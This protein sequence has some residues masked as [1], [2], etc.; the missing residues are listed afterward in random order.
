[1]SKSAPC[2]IFSQDFSSFFSIFSGFTS[3]TLRPG[4]PLT[5]NIP[6]EGD[7]DVHDPLRAEELGGW[8]ENE[9]GK[10]FTRRPLWQNR[11][12]SR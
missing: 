7:V 10:P 1:M 4:M 12:F 2:M 8:G 6:Q 5:Y 9:G 3:I 11:H